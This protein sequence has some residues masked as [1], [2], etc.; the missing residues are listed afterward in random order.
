M[1]DAHALGVIFR[2]A[3]THNA[4]TDR[5]VTDEVLR[6]VHELMKWGPTSANSQPA[7]FVFV[8]SKEAKERLKPARL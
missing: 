1:L 3:R 2:A 8:R 6:Q 7:R 4:F 5:P